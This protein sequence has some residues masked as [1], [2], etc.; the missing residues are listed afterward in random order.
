M[1]KSP[2]FVCRLRHGLGW[3]ALRSFS[4]ECQNVM[5]LAN[6]LE[7]G[8][9][10]VI[11]INSC[12]PLAG[13]PIST[14]EQIK[15]SI[16]ALYLKKF[17]S[18]QLQVEL[19]NAAICLENEFARLHNEWNKPDVAISDQL[20]EMQWESVLSAAKSLHEVLLRLPKKVSMP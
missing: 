3:P 5:Q 6:N 8:F 17:D 19:Q 12:T 4:K 16:H 7:H 13:L 10:P 20:L 11:L 9:S 15:P 1:N 18:K 2:Q 14:L